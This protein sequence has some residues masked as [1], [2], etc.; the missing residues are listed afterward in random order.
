VAL[1]HLATPMWA[2]IESVWKRMSDQNRAEIA[3]LGRSDKEVKERMCA[4]M[5]LGDTTCL[6]F[7]GK[8]QAVFSISHTFFGKTTWLLASKAYFEKG[9]RAVIFSRN[10]LRDMSEKHGMFR[11]ITASEHPGV[12][13]W[14][15][16][17]GY[18]L[19]EQ[20]GDVKI[21]LFER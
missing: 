5:S 4:F 18:K 10:Y 14:M 2:D 21:F 16:L 7:D 8:P 6:F 11:T 1:M 15:E 12:T 19:E 20:R 9:P 3:K 13:R 17:L